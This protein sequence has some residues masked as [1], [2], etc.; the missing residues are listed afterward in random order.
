M[1]TSCVPWP[2]CGSP[3]WPIPGV[4]LMESPEYSKFA[5]VKNSKV[6]KAIDE[7]LVY[8]GRPRPDLLGKQG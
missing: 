7:A 4:T 1:P 5:S 8:I 3:P 2:G 6:Q